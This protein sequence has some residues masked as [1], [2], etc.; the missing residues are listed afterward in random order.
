MTFP[1]N[2]VITK[3]KQA[4]WARKI[5]FLSINYLMIWGDL[6]Q[7]R[8]LEMLNITCLH[9]ENHLDYSRLGWFSS[10]VRPNYLFWFKLMKKRKIWANVLTITVKSEYFSKYINNYVDSRRKR[11]IPMTEFHHREVRKQRLENWEVQTLITLLQNN[12]QPNKIKLI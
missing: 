2:I 1:W 3:Q 11:S 4:A 6:S 5:V 8:N 12:N 10:C 9:D 7:H